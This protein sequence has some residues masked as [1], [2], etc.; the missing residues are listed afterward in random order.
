MTL[1]TA[2]DQQSVPISYSDLI[3]QAAILFVASFEKRPQRC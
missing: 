1:V 3:G 2:F